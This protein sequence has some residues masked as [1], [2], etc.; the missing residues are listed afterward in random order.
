MKHISLMLIAFVCA[1]FGLKTAS[2]YSGRV[3]M[4]RS[5]CLFLSGIRTEIE[6]SLENAA[7]IFEHL[8]PHYSDSLPFCTENKENIKAGKS[9]YESWHISLMN[10]ENT[11]SLKSDD[12]ALLDSFGRNFGTSDLDGQMANCDMHIQ[13]IKSNLQKAE[14][15]M[16]LY[17]K[18][19]A[20]VGFLCGAAVYILFM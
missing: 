14:N 9:F 19:A 5:A 16:K 18:P 4:L 7:G 6:F 15:E 13:L 11:K 20:A 12:I 8:A 2:N 3:R 17:S 1:G 10:K